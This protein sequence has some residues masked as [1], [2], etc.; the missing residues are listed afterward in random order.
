MI[1][2]IIALLFV[3]ITASYGQSVNYIY[4]DANRLTVTGAL[5][6]MPAAGAFSTRTWNSC[7]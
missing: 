2:G 3:P 4:D 5:N 7:Q 1:L 6:I